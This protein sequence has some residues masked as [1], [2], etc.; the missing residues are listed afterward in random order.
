VVFVTEDVN[1]KFN[2]WRKRGVRFNYAPRLR[3]V[4]YERQALAQP[5]TIPA[6][7]PEEQTPIWG[8][9]FTRFKDV[10]GNSFALVGFDEVSREVEAQRRAVADKLEAE[11]RA[12]QELEIAKQ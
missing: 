8:G 4:R 6:A 9:V 1:A 10:D 12:A 7:P 11:R 2:E 3:R 5:S